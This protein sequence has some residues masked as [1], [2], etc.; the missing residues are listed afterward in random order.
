MKTKE[1][2]VIAGMHRSG[3]SALTG[4]ITKLGVSS[5]ASLIPPSPAN[6]RGY[7]ESKEILRLHE[8]ILNFIGS[9]WQD[10]GPW[11]EGWYKSPAI[12]KFAE[13]I[14]GI[15]LEQ[16]GSSS[17]IVVKDPRLC[18]LLPVWRLAARKFNF[19]LKV[20][21]PFRSAAE[22]TESLALRDSLAFRWS[23]L[24]WLRNLIEAERASRG[25]RRSFLSYDDLLSNWRSAVD[26]VSS[27]LE[28]TWPKKPEEASAQVEHFLDESLRRNRA[29]EAPTGATTILDEFVRRIYCGYRGLSRDPE[30]LSCMEDV[31]DLRSELDKV[32]GPFYELHREGQ[33]VQ[34]A[35]NKLIF[36]KLDELSKSIAVGKSSNPS[37][38]RDTVTPPPDETR[39]AVAA[40]EDRVSQAVEL[41]EKA[42][43]RLEV[44]E[45]LRTGLSAAQKE[46][47]RLTTDLQKAQEALEKA[48]E[49]KEN[50]ATQ[51][52][53]VEKELRLEVRALS[54]ELQ[55]LRESLK[56]DREL[57]ATAQKHQQRTQ[58]KLSNHDRQ[59][60]QLK[61]EI[62]D[63]YGEL[64]Y[65]T[66]R[67]LSAEQARVDAERGEKV[68]SERLSVLKKE[69]EN[70]IELLKQHLD[71]V[72]F[73]AAER[74]RTSE[75]FSDGTPVARWR[76]RARRFL[77]RLF[78]LAENLDV[79]RDDNYRLLNSDPLFDKDWYLERYPDVAS[80]Q[81][82][83]L[84]HFIDHGAAELRDPG[85]NFSTSGYLIKNPDV[86]RAGVN[87]LIHYIRYGRDE[88]RV[89]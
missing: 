13:S 86:A 5:P 52:L 75:Q 79:T 64:A 23:Q 87:A 70:N 10:W 24:L 37:L 46:I 68:A 57:L 54:E 81:V 35:S 82:D 26:K 45:A 83:P 49:D 50:L 21:L 12:S 19:N 33:G 66:K 58:D 73:L 27:D 48:A 65:L 42:S 7:W 72:V 71:S 36:Q 2:I 4:V 18:R 63:R 76:A 80:T 22:V 32:S 17:P 15:I 59:V 1:I 29:H 89:W 77:R 39:A 60:D 67:C 34:Q 74:A 28:V 41:M 9:D 44:D 14:P 88:G 61:S 47:S 3:T 25:L 31:D 78:N 43:R 11:P 8:D 84:Q 51:H 69:L 40:L 85:P 62:Q 53:S 38:R 55:T 16:F 56:R 20:A 6:P 30:S